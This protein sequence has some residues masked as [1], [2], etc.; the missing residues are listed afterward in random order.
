VKTRYCPFIIKEG[1]GINIPVELPD[2]NEDINNRRSPHPVL[3]PFPFFFFFF[4]F[5]SYV[6]FSLLFS[7]IKNMNLYWVGV[8]IPGA[9]RVRGSEYKV[10]SL[11]VSHRRAVL[12]TYEPGSSRGCARMDVRT[13]SAHIYGHALQRAA[14]L[15]WSVRAPP[16]GG[17]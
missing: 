1:E 6:L 11:V 17:S 12:C 7:I 2:T 13:G 16:A 8:N 10:Y 15:C 9:N 4:F 14:L 3:A 5:S